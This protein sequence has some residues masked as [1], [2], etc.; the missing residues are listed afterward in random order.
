MLSYNGFYINYT[1][2]VKRMCRFKHHFF[3]IQGDEFRFGIHSVFIFGLDSRHHHY[4]HRVVLSV[5]A[6][7]YLLDS[8]CIQYTNEL[9]NR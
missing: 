7:S 9:L 6:H 8:I 3:N 4:H 2:K 5:S 1:V